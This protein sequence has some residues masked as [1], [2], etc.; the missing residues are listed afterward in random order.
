MK[1]WVLDDG[2]SL[3]FLVDEDQSTDAGLYFWIRY[4]FLFVIAV[5]TTSDFLRLVF[6]PVASGAVLISFAAP[7][8]QT[9]EVVFSFFPPVGKPNFGSPVAGVANSAKVHF[10]FPCP[11]VGGLP[12]QFF[13]TS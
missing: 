9:G 13:F 11:G 1:Q 4:V 8:V 5:T 3:A 2:S 6:V 7:V 10:G 12:P